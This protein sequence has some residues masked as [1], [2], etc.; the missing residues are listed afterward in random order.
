MMKVQRRSM[1]VQGFDALLIENG[2]MSLPIIPNLGSKLSSIRPLRT[3]REW[4][5]TNTACLT[6]QPTL[7]RPTRTAGTSVFLP[8]RHVPLCQ[9]SSQGSVNVLFGHVERSELSQAVAR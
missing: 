1:E 6:P 5:W 3:E 9:V 8:L 2:T 4:F 7:S